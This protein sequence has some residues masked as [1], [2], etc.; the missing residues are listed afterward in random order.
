MVN[1][2]GVPFRNR[3]TLAS[4]TCGFGRELSEL[5]DL[6]LI[7]GLC[8]KGLTLSPRAGNPPPRSAETPMGML[9]S[10]GL[11]NPG[12]DAFIRDELPF[13]RSLGTRVIANF[14][15]ATPEEFAEV[16]ARLADSGVDMLEV[17]ISCPNVKA[18]GMAFGTSAIAAA[19]VTAAV[20][21][22]AGSTPVMVKLS[23]NVTNITDIAHACEDSGAD[24]LSL[25]NTLLGM[26]FD[27]R[28]RSPILANGTG[29]LSGPAIFP[30]ALRMVWQVANAVRIPILGL[31]GIAS[32]DDAC[33]ML[34]AG[35]TLI[36]VGSAMFRD[37]LLPARIA[38]ELEDS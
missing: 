4:G 28:T 34:I 10:V 5:F 30:V 8:T 12:V 37:P 14:S 25:I 32:P 22:V 36:G 27:L 9:N 20:K 1:F 11:Q 6:S 19:Q 38:A 18:E 7:G 21:R 24:A 31:G 17:N 26:R 2:A 16:A 35:A 3:V 23:P 13:M 15:G 33:E 29:G